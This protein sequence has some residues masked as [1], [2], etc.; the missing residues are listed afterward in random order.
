M[1][2]WNVIKKLE[3]ADGKCNVELRVSPDGTL[4]RFYE[5]VWVTDSEEE[6]LYYPEGGYWSC[7]HMSGFYASLEEC[8]QAARAEIAWLK[9]PSAS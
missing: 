4:F 6:R 8:D 9:L 5:N 2:D 1:S 3:R 7:P